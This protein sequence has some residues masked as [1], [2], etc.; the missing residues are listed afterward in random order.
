MK[1]QFVFSQKKSQIPKLGLNT[2][3]CKMFTSSTV[4]LSSTRSH[5]VKKNIVVHNRPCSKNTTSYIWRCF[6]DTSLR[7][8]GSATREAFP[9]HNIFVHPHAQPSVT[10]NSNTS[11]DNDGDGDGCSN[12]R[13]Q[14]ACDIQQARET[15]IFIG[16]HGA[17]MTNVLFMRP[18]SLLV[19]VVGYFD[20]K[21]LPVCGIYGPLAAVFGV[22]HYIYYYDGL[23]DIDD[24]RSGG[25]NS[26]TEGL[27]D[28]NRMMNSVRNYYD[29]LF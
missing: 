29:A 23:Y 19:E 11:G 3:V 4:Q 18:G 17:A 9:E 21:M 14:I 28:M 7:K 13:D 16:L 22:H 27:L 8:L 20:G 26:S 1:K 10:E 24:G 5:Q 25:L 6:T 2:H 15:D 12:C